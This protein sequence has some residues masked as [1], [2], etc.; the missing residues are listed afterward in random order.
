MVCTDVS[1]NCR[2]V[3]LL[4]IGHSPNAADTNLVNHVCKLFKYQIRELGK[5]I[6]W[7]SY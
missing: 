6:L 5:E 1:E 4:Y 7:Q 3:Q 2:S